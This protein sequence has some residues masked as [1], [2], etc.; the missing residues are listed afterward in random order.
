MQ[1]VQQE[2]PRC[3][4][5]L[6]TEHCACEDLP[7]LHAVTLMYCDFCGI[8]TETLWKRDTLG[9]M[10]EEF[11]VECDRSKNPVDL[12]K[13]LQRLKDRRAA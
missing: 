6:P 13:L 9:R 3:Q 8:G 5:A 2:C 11:S 7:P 4:G 10:H 12:G 1:I